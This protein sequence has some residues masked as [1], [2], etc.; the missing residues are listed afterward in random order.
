LKVFYK[1]EEGN[2]LNNKVIGIIGGMGPEATLNLYKKIIQKTKV[3]K[4]QDHFRVIIDSN[5]KIPDRTRAILY[6]EKSPVE[7]IIQT[8]KNLEKLGVDVGCIP[9]ITAHYFIEEI[10]DNLSFPIINPLE[11]TREHL[12]KFYPNI[13]RVGVMATT[14]T[15]ESKLFDKYLPSHNI[16]YPKIDQQNKVMEGIYGKFGIKNGSHN[17]ETIGLLKEVGQSLILKGAEV[18]I[19]GCTELGL[20]LE[21]KDFTIPLLDP[22]DILV[23]KLVE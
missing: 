13:K 21:Q 19:L 16:L 2:V 14:G 5:P 22:M 6:G 10:R 12:L 8:G 11:E 9:C 20:V 23:G 4:D 7:E 15:V 3:E 18:L 17:G 1:R